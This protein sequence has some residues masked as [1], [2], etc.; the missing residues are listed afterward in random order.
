MVN[1]TVAT[2]KPRPNRPL[3][4]VPV[5]L[6]EIVRQVANE[7]KQKPKIKEVGYKSNKTLK[8]NKP[9]QVKKKPNDKRSINQ[10]AITR[11]AK[12]IHAIITEP[13]LAIMLGIIFLALYVHHYHA[14]ESIIARAD[15]W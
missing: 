6:T 10:D 1:T 11:I 13:Q 4:N 2:I 7:I 8:V 5:N 3:V 9:K 12:Q 14:D 15:V